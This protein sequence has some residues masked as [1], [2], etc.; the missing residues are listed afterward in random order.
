MLDLKDL[1]SDSALG[2]LEG[3]PAVLQT[4]RDLISRDLVGA[5]RLLSFV[6]AV[7]ERRGREVD[8]LRLELGLRSESQGQFGR[9]DPMLEQQRTTH[10]EVHV[11]QHPS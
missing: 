1:F 5:A 11:I 9:L 2:M 7:A 4:V 10:V 3:Y 8:A 6:T